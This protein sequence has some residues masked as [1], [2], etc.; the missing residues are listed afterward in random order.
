MYDILN[1]NEDKP[2]AQQIW[3][4]LYNIQ[5]KD[6]KKIYMY[7]MKITEYCTLQW[8]QICINY[9][10]L[11]TN[12]RLQYM[13]IKDDPLCTFCKTNVETT[14]HLLWDCSTTKDFLKSFL[15]WLRSFHI[16]IELSEKLILFGLETGE[17]YQMS[18]NLFYC[19]Q[20]I[21]YAV[22]AAT[23]NHYCFK[24]S[25]KNYISCIKYTWKKHRPITI[26]INFKM[27]RDHMKIY[28]GYKYIFTPYLLN[29]QI[30]NKISKPEPNTYTVNLNYL[31]TCYPLKN[32]IVQT[33]VPPPP[34]QSPFLSYQ[35]Y[36]GIHKNICLS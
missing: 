3:N 24:F 1:I 25:R 27:N 22:L 32:Y 20:N 29:E 26:W 4:N 7:P 28:S 8:F 5:E 10:I 30:L 9:N 21:T 19:M 13:D 23:I 34:Q 12:K 36:T 2:T 17:K 33:K 16:H 6:W 18:V 14:V 15:S 31:H 11:I 35:V